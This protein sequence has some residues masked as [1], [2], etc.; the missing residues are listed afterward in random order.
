MNIYLTAKPVRIA[1]MM[2][3]PVCLTILCHNGKSDCFNQ[4]KIE[5]VSD[6]LCTYSA[7][8]CLQERPSEDNQAYSLYRDPRLWQLGWRLTAPSNAGLG[9]D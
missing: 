9:K 6:S 1:L 5:D 8:G 7:F 4:V 3:Y 2:V